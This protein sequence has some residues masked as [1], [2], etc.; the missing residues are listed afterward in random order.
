MLV[1]TCALWGLSFPVVKA[2]HLE[3]ESR[4]PAAG[5]LFL[6]IWMQV[7]RF[8]LAAM[9]LLPFLPKF[10]R[11]SPLEIRQGLWLALTGGLGM[12]LQAWGL[13]HTEASTSAFLT[14]AYCIFLPLVACFRTRRF[15]DPRTL[16]A[17]VLVLAGGAILAGVRP[18]KLHLGAGETATLLAALIFT[19]QIL[20][21]E[22]PRYADNRGTP[23]TFIM[24]LGIAAGYLPF[25]FLTTSDPSAVWQAGASLPAALFVVTLTLFSSV[26]AFLLM[27]S[28]QKRVSAT[29]AGLI[30]TTE[31]IF[32]ALYALFLPAWFAAFTGCPYPNESLTLPL[33]TGGG[34]IILANLWMQW[35]S[36]RSPSPS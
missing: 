11:P 33:L 12:G 32:A 25:T 14:Q 24:C 5:T 23:V 1:L 17:T 16:G 10:G 31:P 6:A 34:L 26:G 2:L 22:N 21:L 30:Y 20:T 8:G 15:P 3:Q 29:E 35:P 7:A 4:L 18:D 13:A 27:N 19:F 28:W 36:P 9:V